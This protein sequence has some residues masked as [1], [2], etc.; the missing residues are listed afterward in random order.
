LLIQGGY[1][2]LAIDKDSQGNL[3]ELLSEKLSNEFIGKSVL[4]AMQQ[5]VK[6]YIVPIGEN[7]DLLPADN[8]LATFP[9]WIYTGKTYRGE[10]VP[11]RGN[12]A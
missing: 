3:T 4:E 2:E 5:G 8:F 1:K 12:P 7:L 10:N 9:L 11:F 6:K